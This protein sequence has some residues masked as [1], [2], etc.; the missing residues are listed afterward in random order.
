MASVGSLTMNLRANTAQFTRDLKR[1]GK[2]VTRFQKVAGGVGS[3]LKSRFGVAAIATTAIIATRKAIQAADVQ[4]QAE[5]RLAAVIRAT[6]KAAGFTAGQLE[7]MAADLQKVTNFG[8]EV[9]ISALAVLA[10][11]KNIKGDV[12]RQAIEAA[13]DMSAVLGQDLRSSVVTLGKALND[14]ILGVT[15][16]RRV[17]IQMSESQEE[18]IKL[19]VAQNNLMGAQKVILGELQAEMGGVAQASQSVWTKW[20]NAIGDAFEKVGGGITFLAE[21]AEEAQRG[22]GLLFSE[23]QEDFLRN[24]SQFLLNESE[25]QKQIGFE[26]SVQQGE[27]SRAP[28]A[29]TAE[30]FNRRNAE[31]KRLAELFKT[32]AALTGQAFIETQTLHEFEQKISVEKRKQLDLLGQQREA[33]V[34]Q[35][36]Q[37]QIIG[38]ETLSIQLMPNIDTE[39]AVLSLQEAAARVAS[40]GVDMDFAIRGATAAFGKVDKMREEWQR[41][42]KLVLEL[43]IERT[44]EE[45][46]ELKRAQKLIE[47]AQRDLENLGRSRAD[48][49]IAELQTLGDPDQI[50][51]G[52]IVIRQL[53]RMQTLFAQQQDAV[54]TSRD[55]AE[56]FREALLSDADRLRRDMSAAAEAAARGELTP[57]E[58][59][60]TQERLRQDLLKLPDADR[61]QLAPTAVEGSREAFALLQQAQNPLVNIN[62]QI[63][64]NTK[65]TTRKLDGLAQTVEIA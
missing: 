27:I 14:P 11:F 60:K 26:Q 61:L 6:G 12:F 54:E 22:A 25:R 7:L 8:D 53:E 1:A 38:Q 47:Q 49:A 18:S 58:A 35:R 43:K 9:T 45:F 62:K 52:E 46:A 55:N 56:R 29:L 59:L 28:N 20:A 50:R 19:F 37:L 30:Q 10:T 15:A 36:A 64:T 24:R 65:Q 39:S 32:V 41:N 17:G 40:I 4:E 16:L 63:A 23:T 48:I 21:A 13:Q 2:D 5:R 31:A 51:D 33:L 3:F 57:A 44:K 34:E 42:N